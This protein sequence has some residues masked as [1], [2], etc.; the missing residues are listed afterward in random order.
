MR[1]TVLFQR[2]VLFCAKNILIV[3]NLEKYES[4]IHKTLPHDRN[5][6]FIIFGMYP[7]SEKY[8]LLFKISGPIFG[9]LS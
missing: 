3:K 1:F 9:Y 7:L 5:I 2:Q 6:F 8:T 4:T